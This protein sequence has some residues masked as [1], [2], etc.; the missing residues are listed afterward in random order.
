MRKVAGY[1]LISTKLTLDGASERYAK[2]CDS[3]QTWQRS[4]GEVQTVDETSRLALRDGRIAE[5]ET[6][7]ATTQRGEMIELGLTEPT[8][9]GLFQTQVIVS[10][11]EERVALYVEL[12]ASGGPYQVGPMR[13]DVRCP[14]L[15]HQVIDAGD[16]WYVGESLLMTRPMDFVGSRGADEFVAIGWHPNRNLPIVAVSPYEGRMLTE[17]FA[18]DLARDLAGI[19]LVATLDDEASLRLTAVKGKEW[20]CYSG[21]VR[22]Y[23]P[24]VNEVLNPLWTRLSLL[25]DGVAPRDAASRFRRQIRRR[26]MELSAFSVRE[27]PEIAA[28]REDFQRAETEKLRERLRGGS[29]W[30]ALANNYAQENDRLRSANAALTEEVVELRDRVVNLELALRWSSDGEDVTPQVEVPPASVSDA[31]DQARAKHSSFLIFGNDVEEGVKTLTTD[32]G[33][34]EKLALYFSALAEMAAAMRKGPLGKTTILWLRD[35]GIS[36][37][38]ESD[39]IKNSKA[40]MTKRTWHDG[41]KKRAFN[42]HLKPNEA[43]APDRCVRVYFDLE[44]ARDDGSTASADQTRVVVGW[45]GRHP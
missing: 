17:A 24:R 7:K 5:L 15:I 25:R 36:A 19:A 28:I 13:V 20:S 26:I 2:L 38:I 41:T 22:I 44:D 45:V 3:V 6:L 18:A 10:R 31:V 34:P 35:R 12:R 37:S 1:A 29:D 16:D 43:S 39:T 27:F 33:P 9:V 14:N 30:E 42:F 23:W 8:E 40:E 32:A 11:F 21:A 4:K